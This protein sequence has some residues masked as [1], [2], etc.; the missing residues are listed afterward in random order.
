MNRRHT[1]AAPSALKRI[2]LIMTIVILGVVSLLVHTRSTDPLPEMANLPFAFI[3]VDAAGYDASRVT[4]WRGKS[5]PPR[6]LTVDGETAW[7]AYL[8]DPSI[9]PKYD[10]NAWIFPMIEDDNGH[11]HSPPL[12]PLKRIHNGNE[13]GFAT[14]YLTPEAQ[15]MLDRFRERHGQ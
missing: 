10:G 8:A 3:T 6:S 15:E 13:P 12:P 2:L 9:V 5:T 4:I 14:P 11:Q 1:P 7:P